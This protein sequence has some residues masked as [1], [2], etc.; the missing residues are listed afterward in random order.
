[1]IQR[2]TVQAQMVSLEPESFELLNDILS[3][4]NTGRADFTRWSI[5][6]YGQAARPISTG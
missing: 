5:S 3:Q 2:L 4:L 6:K 1:M